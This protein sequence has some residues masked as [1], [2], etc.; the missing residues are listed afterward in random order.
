[1]TN[2]VTV[3]GII[4]GQCRCKLSYLPKG[5]GFGSDGRIKFIAKDHDEFK[6][7]REKYGLP[8]VPQ[9]ISKKRS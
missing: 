7:Q 8:E 4:T 3:N 6:V 9:K 2:T 5:Y 1:M